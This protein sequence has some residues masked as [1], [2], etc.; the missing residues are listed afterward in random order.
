MAGRS[1]VSSDSWGSSGRTGSRGV[2]SRDGSGRVCRDVFLDLVVTT[3]APTFR[4]GPRN[5]TG[6]ASSGISAKRGFGWG[7]RRGG[8]FFRALADRKRAVD[9]GGGGLSGLGR[10]KR[11]WGWLQRRQT[12]HS[13]FKGQGRFPDVKTAGICGGESQDAMT[14]V[15]KALH[16]VPLQGS[17]EDVQGG[18]SLRLQAGV[19]GTGTAQL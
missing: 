8:S 2:P 15:F 6:W 11:N 3:S 4:Y 9:A 17:R 7:P 18:W 16:L 14:R 5:R 13:G 12:E 1:T 19:A 10:E